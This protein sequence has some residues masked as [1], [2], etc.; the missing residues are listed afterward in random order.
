[1]DIEQHDVCPESDGT[2]HCLAPVRDGLALETARIKE[3]GRDRQH[4]RIVVD[5][6]HSRALRRRPGVPRAFHRITAGTARGDTDRG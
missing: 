6:E 1:M 2:G 3:A 4:H 5:D